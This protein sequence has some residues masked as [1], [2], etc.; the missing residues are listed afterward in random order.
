MN[1][2]RLSKKTETQFS[3][4]KANEK[5]KFSMLLVLLSVGNNLWQNDFTKHE[6]SKP[7]EKKPFMV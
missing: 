6:K 5:K 2:T 7:R 4:I 1:A 3:K